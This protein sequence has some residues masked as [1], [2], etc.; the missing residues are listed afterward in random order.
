MREYRFFNREIIRLKIVYFKIAAMK[1]VFLIILFLIILAGVSFAG[2]A[3]F[4]YLKNKPTFEKKSEEIIQNV[5]NE[6]PSETAPRNEDLSRV[7]E[8]KDEPAP[9]S[10][11]VPAP[12]SKFSFAILGDT[13]YFKPGTNGGY[14][15]AASNIKKLNPNL[16]FGIG[17]LI[18]SCD[19]GKECENKLIEWKKVLGSLSSKTYVMMGNHDRVGENK[20]DSIYQKVFE[21]PTNG[22]SGYSELTYSFDSENSHFV[23]LSSDKPE[24]NLINATQ[25][26]WLDK[27]LDLTKKENIFVFFHEPAYPTNS[28]IGESLDENAKDRNALWDIL[29]KHKV[30]A[31]FS[32]H[33]HIQSRRKVNGIYQ[34]VFG[35]TDSFNHLAPKP[36]MAEYS[37]VGQGFGMVEIS[38]T[39]ITVKTYGVGG[40]LLNSFALSK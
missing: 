21:M 18:S 7:E 35:N 26:S 20:A 27:D 8:Q 23:V 30:K 31:V 28:K 15:I 3:F 29:A 25:R 22:P 13:Q 1:K 36:G 19:G 10:E 37:Y 34:F 12:E 39:E 33:E 40:N 14:Q 5:S 11:E 9:V 2:G 6:K 4:A 17:D 24:E 32:G 38:G 16:V